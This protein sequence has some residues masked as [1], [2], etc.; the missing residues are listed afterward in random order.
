MDVVISLGPK[1]LDII[2]S[3]WERTKQNILPKRLFVIGNLEYKTFAPTDAI[4]VDE[5]AFISDLDLSSI[6][7]DRRGWYIQQIIKMTCH[8]I[9]SDISSPYLVIDAD[10]YIDRPVTFYAENKIILGKGEEYHT[11]YFEWMNRLMNQQRVLTHSGICHVMV[12]VPQV[13]NE[14]IDKIEKQHQKSFQQAFIDCVD[15]Y[16]AGLSGASEY[17]L[18]TNYIVDHYPHLVDF[19]EFKRHSQSRYRPVPPSGIF[20]LVSLHWWIG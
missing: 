13:L 3:T 10:T 8:K 7:V 15:K 4:F 20:D 2:K 6:P 5:N 1:D 19:R 14:I 16:H 17:E 9:I 11:P 12:F 18:Y